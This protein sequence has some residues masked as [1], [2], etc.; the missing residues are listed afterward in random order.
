[1][2]E[3]NNVMDSI[4]F[5][6]PALKRAILNVAAL[7][8]TA[9]ASKATDARRALSRELGSI[10]SDQLQDAYL[11][12]KNSQGDF[13]ADIAVLAQSAD[14]LLQT[15]ALGHRLDLENADKR[16]KSINDLNALNRKFTEGLLESGNQFVQQI[17][18]K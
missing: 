18:S 5:D 3:M 9:K 10:G 8:E 2:I 17:T 13:A 16:E 6:L 4:L 12:A 11:K 15:I 1:M 7:S 14:K